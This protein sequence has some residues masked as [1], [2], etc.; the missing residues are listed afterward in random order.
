M[1]TQPGSLSTGVKKLK[2]V[3][4][5]ITAQNAATAAATTGFP[6]AAA[7][8]VSEITALQF[9]LLGESYQAVS[10]QAKAIHELFVGILSA[11]AG[12]AA[13]IEAVSDS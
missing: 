6:P 9:A 13:G 2:C 12:T 5:A 10:A 1:A 8:E 4:S 11:S 3:G 7:D